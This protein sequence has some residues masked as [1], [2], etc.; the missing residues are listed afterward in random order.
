[1]HFNNGGH[2]IINWA[3]Y[4]FQLP[5][6]DGEFTLTNASAYN[7]KYAI[8]FGAIDSNGALYGFSDATS[9]TA[10]KG[11]KIENGSVKIPLYKLTL[12][13][14]Q[15]TAY[16]GN[17]TILS[18]VIIILDNEDFDY[19]QYAANST[20]YKYLLYSTATSNGITFSGG[21]GSADA[22]TGTKYPVSGW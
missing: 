2:A 12:G 8:L 6:T 21:V 4:G 10:L 13:D 9:A 11:F 14:T 18:L 15:F 5:P 20:N 17:D 7:N 22:A 1:M 16:N 19:L 3:L